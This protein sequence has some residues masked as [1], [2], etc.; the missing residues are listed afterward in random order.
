MSSEGGQDFVDTNQAA[1][2][3]TRTDQ[4]GSKNHSAVIYEGFFMSNEFIGKH[5][6]VS[7][8][9]F[10]GVLKTISPKRTTES[11][12][13]TKIVIAVL[14]NDVIFSTNWTQARC[15]WIARDWHGWT[16]SNFGVLL[17][18]R[19]AP[20]SGNEVQIQYSMAALKIETLSTAATWTDFPNWLERLSSSIRFDK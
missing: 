19:K 13:S 9:D 11:A 3:H 8:Q 2:L 6:V 1:S 18:F 5:L 7:R 12:L 15:K 14:G 16:T 4:Y 20:P 17:S 10:V